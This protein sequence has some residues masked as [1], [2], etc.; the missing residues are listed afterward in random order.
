MTGDPRRAGRT[1]RPTSD[2]P[3]RFSGTSAL[4]H[5]SGIGRAV[6]SPRASLQPTLAGPSGRGAVPRGCRTGHPSPHRAGRG[7]TGV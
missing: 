4:G 5:P 3:A 2:C 6:H 7:R 1:C